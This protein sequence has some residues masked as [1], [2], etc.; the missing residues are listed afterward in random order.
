MVNSVKPLVQSAS[1]DAELCLTP[2]TAASMLQLAADFTPE[3]RRVALAIWPPLLEILR[4]ALP[5]LRRV[6]CSLT[7]NGLIIE[8]SRGWGLALCCLDGEHLPHFIGARDLQADGDRGIRAYISDGGYALDGVNAENGHLARLLRRCLRCL[9]SKP[10]DT[11]VQSRR[12]RS[13]RRAGQAV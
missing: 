13:P 11:G 12:R 2:K 8:S 9:G 5:G 4:P 1:G 7:P 10:V 6:E 3:Q